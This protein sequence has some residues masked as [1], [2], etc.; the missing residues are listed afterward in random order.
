VTKYIY[1]IY[2]DGVVCSS[3]APGGS[4]QRA[5]DRVRGQM[6]A[7]DRTALKG[8]PRQS[9]LVQGTSPPAT[10]GPTIALATFDTEATLAG[11]PTFCKRGLTGFHSQLRWRTRK[12]TASQ[13]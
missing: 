13:V 10:L 6:I 12:V 11:S 1:A 3:T 2:V 8:R 5:G 4:R 9:R 7:D